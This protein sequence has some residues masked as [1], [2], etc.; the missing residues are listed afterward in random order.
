MTVCII[1]HVASYKAI[2]TGTGFQHY[3]TM[4]GQYSRR[5]EI[6]YST[7]LLE[8]GSIQYPFI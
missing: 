3:C 5:L 6:T 8:E 4:H 1:S 2:L 7:D